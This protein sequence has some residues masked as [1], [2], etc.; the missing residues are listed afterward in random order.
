MSG[1]E[2]VHQLVTVD[3]DEVQRAED[4]GSLIRPRAD[5]R[6]DVYGLSYDGAIL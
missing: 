2:D 5:R 6:T 3:L 1:T 4:R